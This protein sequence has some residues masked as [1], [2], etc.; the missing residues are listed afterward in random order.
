LLSAVFLKERIFYMNIFKTSI[1][2]FDGRGAMEVTLKRPSILTLAKLGKIPN[3]LLGAATKLF[4]FA[5]KGESVSLKEIGEILHVVAEASL[6]SPEYK[7]IKDD[8]TDEQ[9]ME[10]YHY[11]KEGADG[12]EYFRCF[13]EFSS[14][15]NNGGGNEQSGERN[16]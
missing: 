15:G 1:S 11:A 2:S 8:L 10:I 3:P 9:L 7:K 14:P 12:L 4:E 6:I 16:A 13:R 5:P